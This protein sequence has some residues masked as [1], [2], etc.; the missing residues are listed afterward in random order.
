MLIYHSF[1]PSFVRSSARSLEGK[2][3]T[4][5]MNK[6]KCLPLND[7]VEI[8]GKMLKNQ[9]RRFYHCWP[10]YSLPSSHAGDRGIW[11]RNN[12]SWCDIY[13]PS[14]KDWNNL[15]AWVLP[16]YT[17]T[18]INMLNVLISLWKV[19]SQL[20]AQ[21]TYIHTYVETLSNVCACV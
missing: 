19:A 6:L 20:W 7:F 15:L 10:N 14:C 17:H 18:H 2:E 3:H 11:E 9:K 5:T 13:F 8:T 4:K 1:V 16:A 12:S 21:L